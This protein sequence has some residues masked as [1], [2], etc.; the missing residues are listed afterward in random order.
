VR[1]QN[2]HSTGVSHERA[3]IPAPGVKSLVW[4]GDD[5][6]DWVAG[7]T[8]YSLDGTTIAPTVN[9]A[10]R[11]DAATA[12][13]DGE[14]AV[15]FERLGTKAVLLRNGE[16]VRELN[17]SS[18]CADAYE[19]PVCLWR[20]RERVLIAH[21]P[22]EYNRIEIDDVETGE[23]LTRGDRSPEDFFHSRLQ[24]NPGGT[25]L[26][27]A[28]WVWH[29]WDAVAIFDIEAALRDGR[30]LDKLDGSTPQSRH[31]GLAEEGTACWQSDTRILLGGTD[32]E[33]DPEE[34]DEEPATRLQAKGIAVYDLAEKRCVSAL[35]LDTVPG[36]LMPMSDTHVVTFYDH[37]RLVSLETGAVI[38]EWPD[39]ATGHQLSSIIRALDPL[40]PLALDPAGRRFA[41]ATDE[42]V[43]VV[44]LTIAEN[45][46]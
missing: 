40:P 44:S 5:L 41:V 13:P 4:C 22:D 12:T 27:S 29:P 18:Y 45:P 7:G 10:Y 46:P 30:V 32:E 17:R 24:V 14:W 38:E 16:H 20:S 11:F 9:H 1:R 26:L 28:G 39:L 8:V 43:V 37:P 3:T 34:A 15:I 31:V 33:E 36:T 42:E 6:V 2:E 25:R 19:Y 21:C 23:R 35:R